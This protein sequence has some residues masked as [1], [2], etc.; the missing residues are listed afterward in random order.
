MSANASA[1]PAFHPAVRTEQKA[2][3]ALIGPSGSG[4]TWTALILAHE[5]GERIAVADS[6][7]GSAA[8]YAGETYA[9]GRAFRFDH[10]PLESFAPERYIAA[11]RAAETA[12]YDVLVIDGI[13]HAWAGK[14]GV[15]EFVDRQAARYQN[16]S[17]MAWRD[18]SPK[19]NAFVDALLSCKAHLIVTM[20]SKMAYEIIEDPKT[21]KKAPRKIGLA[22]IQRDGV[23]YE[24]AIVGEMDMDNTLIISKTRFRDLAGGVYRL[25]GPDLG[26]VIREWLTV[27]TPAA[28]GPPTAAASE[29][30]T[31]T[32]DGA[33][34]SG[35]RPNDRPKPSKERQGLYK[36]LADA[37]SALGWDATTLAGLALKQHGKH[38][39]ELLTDDELRAMVDEVEGLALTAAQGDGRMHEWHG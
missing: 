34:S 7:H 25:P 20:R 19:H 12:G 14:D 26:S 31:A 22:P 5:L 28:S 13:S 8:L 2:R 30:G 11:I 35:A 37:A 23:E 18:A 38:S 4:K 32:A 16:N 39:A 15:L 36:R 21:G 33:T 3:I 6:E 24:F 9:P 17:F 27:G 1:V 29:D 10:L